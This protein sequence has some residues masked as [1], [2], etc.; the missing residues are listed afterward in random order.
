M[1]VA[2][3][4]DAAVESAAHDC[5]ADC[6]ELHKQIAEL[7][8]EVAALQAELKKAPKGGGGADPRVDKILEALKNNDAIANILRK[9]GL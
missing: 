4:E 5:K 8:K 7:K 6:A 1:A 9:A 2:K 3:K